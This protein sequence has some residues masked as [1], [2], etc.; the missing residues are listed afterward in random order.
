[1]AR[2]RSCKASSPNTSLPTQSRMVMLLISRV[3]MLNGMR[4]LPNRKRREAAERHKFTPVPRS[5]RHGFAHQPHQLPL[6][7][8][9]LQK[10]K[11]VYA[12]TGVAHLCWNFQIHMSGREVQVQG[13]HFSYT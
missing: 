1:L 6:S 4:F 3:V 11:S 12:A 13:N 5:A 9:G 7:R 8:G 10:L 2:S